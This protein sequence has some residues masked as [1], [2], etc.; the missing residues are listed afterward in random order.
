MP[1]ESLIYIF[2]LA[3]RDFCLIDHQKTETRYSS[4]G[5]H[6]LATASDDTVIGKSLYRKVIGVCLISSDGPYKLLGD[7]FIKQVYGLEPPVTKAAALER[8]QNVAESLRT[9]YSGMSNPEKKELAL[10]DLNQATAQG[11]EGPAYDTILETSGW[12]FQFSNIVKPVRMWHGTD[13]TDVPVACSEFTFSNLSSASKDLGSRLEI[14][15]NENHTLLR[16]HWLPI[17]KD[18]RLSL[19]KIPDASSGL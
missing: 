7:A 8:A 13:D 12:D 17:L 9:A 15:S 14:T 2:D 10:E 5:P 4:G 3:V 18:I 19:F 6:A 1:G 11:L 16:R